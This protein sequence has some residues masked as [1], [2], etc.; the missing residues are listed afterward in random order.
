MINHEMYYLCINL[1]IWKSANKNFAGVLIQLLNG[2]GV[3][4]EADILIQYARSI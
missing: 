2:E 1:T 3:K 4:R